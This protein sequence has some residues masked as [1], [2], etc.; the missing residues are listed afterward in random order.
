MR[1]T[2]HM[3]GTTNASEDFFPPVCPEDSSVPNTPVRMYAV[4]TE[5][6]TEEDDIVCGVRSGPSGETLCPCKVTRRYI[7]GND[8]EF[9]D[10]HTNFFETQYNSLVHRG[11]QQTME[12]ARI[13]ALLMWAVAH[14][15]NLCTFR[16]KYRPSKSQ[17]A[18]GG[19]FR[20]GSV[21]QEYTCGAQDEPKKVRQVREK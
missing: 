19:G 21:V 17:R 8:Y 18:S 12:N 10:Y 9:C 13:K 14:F 11:D 2:Y 20:Q 3:Y 6:I 15:R 1:L 4:Y 16:K 7:R 5:K